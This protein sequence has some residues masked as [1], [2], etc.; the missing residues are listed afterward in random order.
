MLALRL[1]AGGARVAEVEPPKPSPGYARVRVALAGV[2]N[3]DLELVK[4]YMGFR[5]VLGHEFV[6]RV[7]AGPREW[8]GRLPRVVE[9][10]CDEAH[11][12]DVEAFLKPRMEKL[13][14]GP[15][16]LAKALERI[17][18]CGALRASQASSLSQ[19][20]AKP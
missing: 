1:D 11:R 8:L 10:F 15:R 2:C 3:T 16:N 7:D 17:R 18:L 12:A 5:G 9:P 19:F 6:G 13:P 20:L 14:G 4:G